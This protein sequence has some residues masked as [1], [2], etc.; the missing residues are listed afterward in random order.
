MLSEENR[1]LVERVARALAVAE[2]CNP[3]DPAYV[4][5]PGAV[6]FGVCWRDKYAAKARAAIAA[7]DAARSE[8][9]SLGEGGK[10]SQGAIVAR[11]RARPD[12]PRQAGGEG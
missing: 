8:P 4:R 1:A 7:I 2:G 3:D 11:D 5:F 9:L 12:T 10:A 6:P